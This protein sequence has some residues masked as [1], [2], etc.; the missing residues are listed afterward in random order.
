MAEQKGLTEL[1]E[2]GRG[3]VGNSPLPSFDK[4][5]KGRQRVKFCAAFGKRDK[6]KRK[7][8]KWRYCVG[9]DKIVDNLRELKSGDYVKVK[10]W[11]EVEEQTDEFY[12]PVIGED[13]VAKTREVLILISAKKLMH[14]KQS[15]MQP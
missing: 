6:E 9:Y 8:P 2:V 12:R 15:D 7:Y 10:G 1:I 13:G 5:T 14:E 4:T 3:F 11:L